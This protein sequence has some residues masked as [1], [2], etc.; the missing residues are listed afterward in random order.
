MDSIDIGH[1]P[2]PNPEY[3]WDFTI[4]Q[5]R[6]VIEFHTSIRLVGLCERAAQF[7]MSC[8][9]HPVVEDWL[10][11][12][13]PCVALRLLNGEPYVTLTLRKLEGKS[14]CSRR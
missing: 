10:K 13:R 8:V 9:D 11:M 6:V 12:D 1:V 4:N 2:P 5:S 7:S 3:F 14:L